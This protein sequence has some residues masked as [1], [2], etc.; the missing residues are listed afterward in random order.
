MGWSTSDLLGVFW[1]LLL[2]GGVGGEK[3]FWVTFVA[4]ILAVVVVGGSLLVFLIRAAQ[5]KGTRGGQTGANHAGF[6]GGDGRQPPE[7]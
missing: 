4:L 6:R 5:G 2:N 3:G 1:Y 7:G